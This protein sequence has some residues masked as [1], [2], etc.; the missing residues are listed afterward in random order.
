MKL[1]ILVSQQNQSEKVLRNLLDSIRIQQGI[2][3]S[4]IEVLLGTDD[5]EVNLSDFFLASY[6]YSIQYTRYDSNVWQRLLDEAT[7]EYVM[8]CNPDCIFMSALGFYTL[9]AYMQKGFDI[10]TLG[11]IKEV[12]DTKTDNVR[13]LPYTDNKYIHGK[14]YRRRH[15]VDKKIVWQAEDFDTS[16]FNL[17]A[18]ETAMTKEICKSSIYLWKDSIDDLRTYPNTIESNAHLIKELLTRNLYNK[19]KYQIGFLVYNTYFMLNKSTWLDPM[20][21]KY[22]YET[23]KKFKQYY[24]KH[25]E[26]FNTLDQ[27]DKGFII[28][29]ILK[30]AQFEGLLLVNFTFEDWMNHIEELD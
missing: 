29:N 10:L 22:R 14:V 3:F 13:Y 25:K 11:G 6:P 12:Y 19:A 5:D 30:Q 7:A 23:E 20:N 26:L 21:A 24:K 28:S 9:F 27:T 17:L 16:L 15:L 18:R 8:L 2:D 4:E 1:Q